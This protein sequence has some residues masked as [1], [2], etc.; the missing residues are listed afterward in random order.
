MLRLVAVA[1]PVVAQGVRSSADALVRRVA[2]Q[3]REAAIAS[4]SA[5]PVGRKF[6][7]GDLEETGEVTSAVSNAL[8]AAV[9][10]CLSRA[11]TRE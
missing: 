5:S 7:V 10:Q 2:P 6:F 3:E 11:R 8:D 9:T 4:F 1:K